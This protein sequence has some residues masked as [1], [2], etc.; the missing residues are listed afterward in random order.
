VAVDELVAPIFIE[1]G[2]QVGGAWRRRM[3]IAIDRAFGL[4]R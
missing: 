2:Q 4:H 1:I 3:K